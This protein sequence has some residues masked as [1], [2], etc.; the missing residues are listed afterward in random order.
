[1]V[2]ESSI[3]KHEPSKVFLKDFNSKIVQ[4]A[5][6]KTLENEEDELTWLCKAAKI[7]RKNIF[8]KRKGS[9]QQFS[10]TVEN[11]EKEVPN[12]LTLFLKWVMCG[13]R[14]LHGKRDSNIDIAAKTVANIIV[15]IS[16]S[17]RQVNYEPKD[18]HKAIFRSHF[19]NTQAISLGLGIR[20]GGRSRKLLDLLY[21]F[22]FTISNQEC[23]LWENAIAN[24]TISNET[25]SNMMGFL[26][27]L[28]Y[29]KEYYQ[30]FT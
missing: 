15:Y 14:K 29:E 21:R 23:L 9:A 30:F 19:I 6:E 7:L 22:G 24:E 10:A 20:K 28:V 11:T 18:S 27:H 13:A 5:L 4:L 17:D 2:V 26:Y 16:K 25:I 12:D 3:N 1:M 8:Q